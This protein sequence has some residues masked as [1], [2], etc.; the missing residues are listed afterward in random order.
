LNRWSDI[1]L[2][3]FFFALDH[4]HIVLYGTRFFPFA[5]KLFTL[6]F[7]RVHATRL[8]VLYFPSRP[9][10]DACMRM[11]GQ[12]FPKKGQLKFP[13]TLVGRD[14]FDLLA[15]KDNHVLDIIQYPYA[16]MFWKGCRNI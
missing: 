16:G 14:V 9:M 3:Q 11:W 13:I 6:C 1:F 8:V 12:L 7:D 15:S 5:S 10:L 4:C 2:R